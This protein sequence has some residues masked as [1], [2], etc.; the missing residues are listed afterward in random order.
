MQIAKELKKKYKNIK[1]VNITR[2][3]KMPHDGYRVFDNYK[4]KK[5]FPNFKFT[6]LTKSLDEIKFQYNEKNKSAKKY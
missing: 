2:K 6:S 5:L 4:I 1:I 3:Q